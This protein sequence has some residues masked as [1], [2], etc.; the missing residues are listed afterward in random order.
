[1]NEGR[2]EGGEESLEKRKFFEER[3]WGYN[4]EGVRGRQREVGGM[5]KREG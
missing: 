5:E 3:K 4:E 1:M 2:G